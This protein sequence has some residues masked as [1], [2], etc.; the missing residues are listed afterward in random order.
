MAWE[1]QMRVL[2]FQANAKGKE[3]EEQ[4]FHIQLKDEVLIHHLVST[5]KPAASLSYGFGPGISSICTG[6]DVRWGLP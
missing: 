6:P 4:F 3:K 5:L 2:S 1:I